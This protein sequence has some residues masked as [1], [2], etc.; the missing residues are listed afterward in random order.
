MMSNNVKING[1]DANSIGTNSTPNI[2]VPATDSIQEFIV[3]TSLMML[4]TAVT[5]VAVSRR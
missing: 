5:L 1:I 3:Q 2:A 4:Q